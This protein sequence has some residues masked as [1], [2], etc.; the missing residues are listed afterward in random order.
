MALECIM[1]IHNQRAVRVVEYCP[2]GSFTRSDL[3][4]AIDNEATLQ[5]SFAQSCSIVLVHQNCKS[6]PQ[7]LVPYA[8]RPSADEALSAYHFCSE[9]KS[10]NIGE[11]H[12]WLS[13]T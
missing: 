2:F 8:G 9:V 6:E 3:V 5:F 10:V 12:L 1:R 4:G 7:S 11:V 13:G